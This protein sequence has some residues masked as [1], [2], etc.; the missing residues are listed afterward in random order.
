MDIY[1]FDQRK[2]QRAKPTR[3][4]LDDLKA[5]RRERPQSAFATRFKLD[6]SSTR[7][8]RG[9]DAEQLGDLLATPQVSPR[10][11]GAAGNSTKASPRIPKVFEQLRSPRGNLG[12]RFPPIVNGQ[13]SAPLAVGRGVVD[14]EEE[15]EEEEDP[16]RVAFQKAQFGAPNILAQLTRLLNGEL[17]EVELPATLQRALSLGYG[18]LVYVG[19]EVDQH[20]HLRH[21]EWQTEACKDMYL[22]RKQRLKEE[23][24]EAERMMQEG[25]ARSGHTSEISP[26]RRSSLKLNTSTINDSASVI[27]IATE[28]GRRQRKRSLERSRDSVISMG[29]AADGSDLEQGALDDKS[30]G[31]PS[32]RYR[33]ESAGP[34]HDVPLPVTTV[35]RAPNLHG[36][37]LTR[38]EKLNKSRGTHHYVHEWL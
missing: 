8:G 7:Q 21:R 34:L 23:A 30:H 24:E 16:Q 14:E 29:T 3:K 15:D 5:S 32:L 12:V 1:F 33:R 6:V 28:D 19:G 18:Q 31:P 27:T 25:A 11:P 36:G 2:R 26:R 10:D 17:I 22:Q 4:T 13:L 37:L 35:S 9:S 20:L 38:L